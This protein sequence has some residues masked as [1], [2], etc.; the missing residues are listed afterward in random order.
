MKFVIQKIELSRHVHDT[1]TNYLI[2]SIY[3]GTI[4]R[5]LQDVEYNYN[6]GISKHI[7]WKNILV[8][9]EFFTSLALFTSVRKAAIKNEMII[10]KRYEDIIS[11]IDKELKQ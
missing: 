1:G 2:A 11:L 6:T 4:R 9:P 5:S 10:K 3:P 7:N 8:I